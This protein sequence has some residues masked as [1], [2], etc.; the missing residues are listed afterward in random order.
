MT[1]DTLKKKSMTISDTITRRRALFI[2]PSPLRTK[3]FVLWSDASWIPAPC[4]W[5]AALRGLLRRLQIGQNKAAR[6]VPL[7]CAH[8]LNTRGR[9]W[10]DDAQNPTQL[11]YKELWNGTI[12]QVAWG[13]SSWIQEFKN[14]KFHRKELRSCWQGGQQWLSSAELCSLVSFWLAIVFVGW[15][16]GLYGQVIALH[17]VWTCRVI[18]VCGAQED[19]LVVKASANGDPFCCLFYFNKQ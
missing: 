8:T 16:G 11:L 14:A 3:P 4:F 18:M 9:W 7:R 17:L 10:A 12:F 15:K 19:W 1:G 13:N 5:A 2:P 6:L